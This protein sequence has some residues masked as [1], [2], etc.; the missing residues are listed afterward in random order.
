M[1]LPASLTTIESGAFED[2]NRLTAINI[3]KR[4]TLEFNAFKNCKSLKKVV[5]GSQYR[6]DTDEIYGIFMGCPFVGPR[7]TSVPACVTFND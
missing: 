1:P 2:C 4:V 5:V 7:M 6:G 3:P